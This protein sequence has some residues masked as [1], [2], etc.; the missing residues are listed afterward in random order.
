MQLIRRP[1]EGY[2]GSDRAPPAADTD[3]AHALGGASGAAATGTDTA[4]E[5]ART[6]TALR[7]GRGVPEVRKQRS[8]SPSRRWATSRSQD[9]C[10][11]E[12][13]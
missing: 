6:K 8:W 5:H 13:Y 2:A 12:Q 9:R 4:V 7:T 11:I 3:A 1:Q 10:N